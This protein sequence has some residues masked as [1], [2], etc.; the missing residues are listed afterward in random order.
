MYYAKK[1]EAFALSIT[2]Q[3]SSAARCLLYQS[4]LLIFLRDKSTIEQAINKLF[5]LRWRT[6]AA[7]LYVGATRK[8]GS[9]ERSVP[10]RSNNTYSSFDTNTI[11]IFCEVIWSTRVPTKTSSTVIKHYIRCIF[12]SFSMHCTI[13][14]HNYLSV[15]SVRWVKVTEVLK[16]LCGQVPVWPGRRT[17]QS[18]APS[19][20]SVPFWLQ[21]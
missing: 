7:N 11:Q 9:D 4:Q 15:C 10:S 5:L 20:I 16:C 18:C 13:K 2:R 1:S 6:T 12:T 17:H 21:P 3:L 8:E 19:I 14:Q